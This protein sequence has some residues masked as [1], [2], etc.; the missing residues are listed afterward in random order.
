MNCCICGDQE[1]LGKATRYWSPDD[2]WRF[3]R[4]C[5]A[6]RSMA[7]RR[8]EPSDYAYDQRREYVTDVDQ[9]IDVVFG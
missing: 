6:C 3:G 2:G 8:P 9:A 1:R 7:T 5:R 4:F